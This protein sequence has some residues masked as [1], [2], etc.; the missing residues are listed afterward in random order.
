M[1][2]RASARGPC[3]RGERVTMFTTPAVAPSPYSTAPVPRRISMRSMV[4]SGIAAHCT[5]ERSK[6]L[7]RRPSTS[8]RVFCAPVMPKPR[9]SIAVPAALLPK[10]SRML[11]PGC[12][13]SSSG[14]V[15][16]ALLAMAAASSTVTLAGRRRTS[17]GKR[18]AVMTTASPACPGA[19]GASAAS[20]A[21][22]AKRMAKPPG[23]IPDAHK[24]AEQ[25][26]KAGLRTREVASHDARTC[27]LPMERV[28]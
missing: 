23:V 3:L 15:R 10:K 20:S 2:P 9:R 16:A 27:R 26:H 18:G 4:A 17:S 22:M 11:I 14:S 19:A 5:P 7:M 6:S 21:K 13:A 8:T 24:A 1:R 28:P 25:R 12:S